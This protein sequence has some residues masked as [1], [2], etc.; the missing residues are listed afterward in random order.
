M[1]SNFYNFFDAEKIVDDFLEAVKQKFIPADNVE[2]Q[3]SIYLVNYQPA[4]SNVIIELEDKRI[5][6]TE[7]YRCVFLTNF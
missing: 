5:W 7:V 3:G 2:D 4:Q 1:H 6:L